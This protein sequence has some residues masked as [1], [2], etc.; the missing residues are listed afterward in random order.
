M[1]ATTM[2]SG[3]DGRGRLNLGSIGMPPY[4]IEWRIV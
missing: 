1:S 4:A 2:I 3:F